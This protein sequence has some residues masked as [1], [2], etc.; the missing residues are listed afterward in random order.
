M[1]NAQQAPYLILWCASASAARWRATSLCSA[2]CGAEEH[3]STGPSSARL[4]PFATSAASLRAG[5]TSGHP[6]ATSS[7]LSI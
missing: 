7:I 6:F 1:L 3:K 4:I 2:A 5:S